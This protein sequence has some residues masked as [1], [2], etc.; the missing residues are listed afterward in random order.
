MQDS[1]E[2]KAVAVLDDRFDQSEMMDGI[3]YGPM[4]LMNE[5]LQAEDKP[6]FII[7]IG[8]NEVIKRNGASRTTICDSYS[9]FSSH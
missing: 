1:A 6:L 5:W 4:S 8:S 9:F 7:A 2:Y 3:V